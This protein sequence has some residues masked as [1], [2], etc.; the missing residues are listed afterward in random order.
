MTLEKAIII[1]EAAFIPGGKTRFGEYREAVR[2]LTKAGEHI[3]NLK[4]T[5]VIDPD[6][7]LPGES[8]E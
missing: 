4:E 5:G 1:V 8:K 3:L 7:L 2:L 6:F